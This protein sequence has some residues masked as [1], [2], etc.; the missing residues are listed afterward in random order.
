LNSL[1][2]AGGTARSDASEKY[3]RV[4]SASADALTTSLRQVAAKITATCDFPLAGDVTVG[5]I[6]AYLDND[7]VTQDPANGWT[8]SGNVVTF[9]GTSCQRIQNGDV[10]DVQIVSGCPTVTIK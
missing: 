8:I 6:N 4:D 2:S 7:L 10:L 5:T 1:A 9:V 3:Y